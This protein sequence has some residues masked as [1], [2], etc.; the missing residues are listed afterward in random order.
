[1][2]RG[3]DTARKPLPILIHQQRRPRHPGE[4]HHVV[5]YGHTQVNDTT[6]HAGSPWFAR[7]SAARGEGFQGHSTVQ[8]ISE[9]LATHGY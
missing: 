6:P 1:M 9:T 8:T 4:D 7:L 3:A 2:L 5:V